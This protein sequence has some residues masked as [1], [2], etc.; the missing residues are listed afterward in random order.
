MLNSDNKQF[1]KMI[2]NLQPIL[3]RY[4]WIDGIQTKPPVR[5]KINRFWDG[6]LTRQ[7]HVS[8]VHRKSALNARLRKL[9]R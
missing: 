7:D 3:S 1:R 6:R 8:R 9:G 2:G 5:G 4:T